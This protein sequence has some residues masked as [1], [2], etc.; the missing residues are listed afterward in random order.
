MRKSTLKKP[1][2]IKK[3]E[4]LPLAVFS[5]TGGVCALERVDKKT[6]SS[7]SLS[8]STDGLTFV[9]DN[10]RVEIKLSASTPKISKKKILETGI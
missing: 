3:T 10:R 2:K 6:T 9:S 5:V 8:W 1:T 7:L 4:G